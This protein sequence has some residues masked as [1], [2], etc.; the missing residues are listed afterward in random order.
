MGLGTLRQLGASPFAAL[1]PHVAQR[2]ADPARREV[3]SRISLLNGGS[4]PDFDRLTALAAAGFNAPVSLISLIDVDK[5][6]F[7]SSHGLEG[8]EHPTCF[9]FCAHAITAEG[10]ILVVADALG[11][12][13]FPDSATPSGEGG[14]RFYAGAPIIVHGQKI[15]T[16]CVINEDPHPLPDPAAV[17]QL[18]QLAALA[19][20]LFV[21]KDNARKGSIAAAALVRAEKRHK[22]ALEAATIA[23]W[24]WDVRSGMVDCDALLPQLFNLQPATR[25]KARH[26]F[27]SIDRRD[28][29]QSDRE[30]MKAIEVDDDYAGEYRVR[31]V[32]PA[33]WLAT[34]GRVIE[35]DADGKPRLVIGVSYDISGRK[36]TEESQRRLLRELN[37]RVKNTLA[38]VQ[39]LASQTVRHARQPRD[40][41]DAF[42]AR[43]QGLGRA[44]GL[45]SDYEWRGIDLHEL[46]LQQVQPFD[47]ARASRIHLTGTAVWLMPDAAV[48][49]G[50]ILHEL[51]SNAMRY[52]ALSVPEGSVDVAWQ[53]RGPAH[54]RR[55]V[56]SWVES[57]GPQVSEPDRSGFGSILIRRSL[58]KILASKVKHEFLPD[59]V[60]AEISLPL[61]SPAA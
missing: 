15:G 52:G 45:L 24:V 38:T 34:R 23:S 18:E 53:L 9:S 1:P 31:G 7:K 16:L 59:G 6:W 49:L 28:L 19:A 47:D 22:L 48:G 13:R 17:V 58:D 41:L 3:L 21:L 61:E 60:R 26:L 11:D 44:H 51:A 4:D 50:L 8:R 46:I 36:S 20:S 35:R 32:C 43:L 54:D 12:P 29:R 5:Q 27:F 14:V 56:L 37:H 40:F 42:S 25:V 30:L 39:A 2:I 55:I 33:R 10:Q 57:G